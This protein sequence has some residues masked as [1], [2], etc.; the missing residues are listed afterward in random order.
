MKSCL[1]LRPASRIGGRSPARVCLS[2]RALNQ[3]RMVAAAHYGLDASVP[4][5]LFVGGS[6]GAAR[7]NEL[8][9]AAGQLDARAYVASVW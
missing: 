6:L 3:D 9:I 2:I 7:I 4:V 5:V 1:I 8:A